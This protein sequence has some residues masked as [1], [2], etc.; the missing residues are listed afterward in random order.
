MVLEELR[1][2][3]D[4]MWDPKAEE[5]VRNTFPGL[6]AAKLCYNLGSEQ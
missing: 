1:E 4:S 2:I 5:V 3:Q 6:E